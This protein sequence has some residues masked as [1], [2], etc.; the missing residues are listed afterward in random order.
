MG[1]KVPEFKTNKGTEGPFVRCDKPGGLCLGI[2][3]A[4]GVEP[5]KYDPNRMEKRWKL[6]RREDT[7]GE[8]E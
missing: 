1:N 3:W 7:E 6:T 8:R 4:R 5:G 2:S